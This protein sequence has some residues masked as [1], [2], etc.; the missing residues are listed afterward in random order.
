[1][2]GMRKDSTGKDHYNPMF[3]GHT[4]QLFGKSWIAH[5]IRI[6]RFYNHPFNLGAF[7]HGFLHSLP[8]MSIPQVPFLRC[9]YFL[10][11]GSVRSFKAIGTAVIPRKGRVFRSV[12]VIVYKP[13][14]L[15][16]FFQIFGDAS[17]C[18]IPISTKQLPRR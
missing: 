11:R 14:H 3:S 17:S 10:S 1:M 18:M 7:R 9:L 8:V 5:K 12:L 13:H 6:G 2:I 15:D 4:A 16:G